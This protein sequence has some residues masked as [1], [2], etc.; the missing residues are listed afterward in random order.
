MKTMVQQCIVS[1]VERHGKMPGKIL[2][3]RDGVSQG[4]Y[5]AF[6]EQ[7]V[8]AIREAFGQVKDDLVSKSRPK[9]L[10]RLE[11]VQNDKDA[12]VKITAVVG[13]KRHHT[14]F[15]PKTGNEAVG[16]GENCRFGT[17]VDAGPTSP[18]HYDFYLQAHHGLEGTVK[19]THYFVVLDEIGHSPRVLQELV[20]GVILTWFSLM[21][22]RTDKQ[23]LVCLPTSNDASF[24][25]GT[26]ILRRSSCGA[27]SQVP[28]TLP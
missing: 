23:S 19:P 5:L 22:I 18:Y 21:L 7:E 16:K 2:F 12:E 11:H 3:Y 27:W 9:Y 6:K 1:H 15:Y 10:A 8:K 14:R 4:Q 26:N 24:L 25:R 28:Q 13:E 17:M 20:S